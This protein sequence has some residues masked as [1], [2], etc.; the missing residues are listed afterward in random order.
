MVVDKDISDNDVAVASKDFGECGYEARRI[1]HGC[2][3]HYADHRHRRLL[4]VDGDRTEGESGDGDLYAIV[5]RN[6][7][8]IP[9]YAGYQH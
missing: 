6:W 7:P 8:T 5:V 3:S 4:R 2:A 1:I 9:T